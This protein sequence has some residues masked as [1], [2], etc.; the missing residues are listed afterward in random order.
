MKACWVCTCQDISQRWT[1]QFLRDV[2]IDSSKEGQRIQY[3]RLNLHGIIILIRGSIITEKGNKT[4][5][6]SPSVKLALID[7]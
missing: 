2:A 4:L 3:L 6:A 5:E 1:F 7:S